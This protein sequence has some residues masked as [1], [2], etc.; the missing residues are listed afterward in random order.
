MAM[1]ADAVLIVHPHDLPFGDELRREMHMIDR[2]LA[3]V[4]S[5][6]AADH[7][8]DGDDFFVLAVTPRL[9]RDP[10]YP[11]LRRVLEPARRGGRLVVVTNGFEDATPALEDYAVE[12][13]GG[14]RSARPYDGLERVVG[15]IA[16]HKA[17]ARRPTPPD[18]D[19][20]AALLGRVAD[21]PL[22]RRTLSLLRSD[23][24]ML[25]GDLVSR[26]EAELLRFPNFGP[27]ALREVQAALEPLGLRVGMGVEGWPPENIGRTLD[28]RETARRAAGL[29]QDRVGATF[30]PA[31]DRLALVSAGE[32]GDVAAAMRPMTGQ[33][34]GAILEKARGFAELSVRLGNQPGWTGIDRT[35]SALVGLLNRPPE[36]VPDVLGLLYSSALELG[37]YAELD[38]QLATGAASYAAPLDP[39]TRRP[40]T[41]LVRNLAPW[42]RTFPSIRELDEQTSSF[43]VRAAS[44]RPAMDVLA[45]AAD[46]DLV[47]ADDVAVLR[48]L[49]AAA[50]RGA[51][52]GGKAGGRV[53]HTVRNLVVAG[54]TVVGSFLL[55]SV[56]SDFSTTSPLVHKITRFLHQ[57]EI[58]IERLVEDA[59][60]DLRHA[61]VDLVKGMAHG[62]ALPGRAPDPDP[63]D[64]ARSRGGRARTSALGGR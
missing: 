22:S 48:R 25:V 63:P 33:L 56:S 34:Q 39:E 46:V 29:V 21:L 50:E 16:D 31:D 42:L 45:T 57:S 28:W 41:D 30:A 19:M 12:R 43:L 52:Q 18:F 61:V 58:A 62:P 1:R 20:H 7:R 49:E 26:T 6:P 11:E 53:H 8:G 9:I 10:E 44:L 37:S 4:L 14:L 23:N 15:R 3:V 36:Q 13:L 55:S 54:T 40:L 35:A 27:K 24:V 51:F 5:D 38:Q 17:R 47:T 2:S 59:S 60:P 64:V 32:E